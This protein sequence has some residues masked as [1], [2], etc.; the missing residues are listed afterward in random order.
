M[1]KNKVLSPT[2]NIKIKIKNYVASTYILSSSF[3]SAIGGMSK[4]PSSSTSWESSSSFSPSA[5]PP[6]LA[7]CAGVAAGAEV[8]SGRGEAGLRGSFKIPEETSLENNEVMSSWEG[9]PDA[10][11]AINRINIVLEYDNT[12]AT[13]ITVS[14]Q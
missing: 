8:W 7:F 14:M 3:T 9:S 13:G 10:G 5:S 1:T 6:S 4:E 2:Y 12:R 11:A